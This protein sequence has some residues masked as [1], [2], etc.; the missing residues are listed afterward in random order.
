M[1]TTTVAAMPRNFYDEKIENF[2]TCLH[3]SGY[4]RGKLFDDDGAK[5]FEELSLNALLKSLQA[6]VSA[7]DILLLLDEM[8]TIL[9][10]KNPVVK[11][12]CA[13][14][15]ELIKSFSKNLMSVIKED[16]DL[17]FW[18]LICRLQKASEMLKVVI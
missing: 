4:L 13:L 16:K 1:I 11:K 15:I 2:L 18:R 10:F 14:E 12:I 17:R 3:L 9:D 5:I 6:R 8:P 7:T